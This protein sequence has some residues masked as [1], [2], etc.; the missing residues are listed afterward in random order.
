MK[1]YILLIISVLSFVSLVGCKSNEK[2]INEY[3]K[4][5]S[6]SLSSVRLNDGSNVFEL[7]V[8]CFNNSKDIVVYKYK[9]IDE[10]KYIYSH[11]YN[12]R[13]D[14]T[15]STI[16]EVNAY[17]DGELS[18]Q[19]Y[20]CYFI[21]EA[22]LLTSE[23]ELNYYIDSNYLELKS[24]LNIN[25]T[26]SKEDYQNY[27]NQVGFFSD[28]NEN[29]TIISIFQNPDWKQDAVK[30]IDYFL[31]LNSYDEIEYLTKTSNDFEKKIIERVER[32][33]TVSS[34][35]F[36]TYQNDNVTFCLG[37]KNNVLDVAKYSLGE[38]IKYIPY[39]SGV[40]LP[41][42]TLMINDKEYEYESIYCGSVLLEVNT[43]FNY[44]KWILNYEELNYRP[45][46][47][48]ED[49][50]SLFK[51][52]GKITYILGENTHIIQTNSTSKFVENINETQHIAFVDVD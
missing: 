35:Y 26:L 41:R 17:M 10:D 43:H 14:D 30:N 15:P 18:L 32:K 6:I 19:T 33:G 36:I 24:N 47:F 1:K 42:T 44:D 25:K 39:Q 22:G 48:E 45:C 8:N 12:K 4:G 3:L 38:D 11:V 51:R 7:D 29:S 16:H 52:Q 46:I 13:V 5:K 34:D 40:M 37:G 28:T 27:C 49:E 23:Y 50:F 9:L 2:T 20:Q 21:G 31:D